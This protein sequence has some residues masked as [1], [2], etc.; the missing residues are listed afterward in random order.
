MIM[1]VENAWHSEVKNS[2]K[3]Q[4]IARKISELCC[5]RDRSTPVVIVCALKLDFLLIHRLSSNMLYFEALPL[6]LSFWFYVDLFAKK[7]NF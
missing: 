5:L 6:H 1:F 7:A 4:Y 2:K 3:I